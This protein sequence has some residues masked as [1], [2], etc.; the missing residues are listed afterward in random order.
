MIL[1]LPIIFVHIF[2][3]AIMINDNIDGFC[4]NIVIFAKLL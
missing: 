4:I 2:F 1:F 3:D